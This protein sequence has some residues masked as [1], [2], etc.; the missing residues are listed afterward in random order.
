[1]SVLKMEERSCGRLWRMGCGCVLVVV[2]DDNLVYR[3]E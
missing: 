2:L 1:M 3:I